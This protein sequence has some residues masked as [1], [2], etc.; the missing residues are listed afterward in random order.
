MNRRLNSRLVEKGL[1]EGRYPSTEVPVCKPMAGFHF[2]S[3][4]MYSVSSPNTADNSSSWY[5]VRQYICST[6]VKTSSRS[7]KETCAALVWV[8]FHG[9]TYE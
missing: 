2:E 5:T 7:G 8:S 1:L 9:C 3:I 4:Q 6:V